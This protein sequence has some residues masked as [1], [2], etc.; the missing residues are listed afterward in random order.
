MEAEQV[1]QGG[2]VKHCLFCKKEID[3]CYNYCNWDCMVAE[4]KANGGQVICPNGLPIRSI[5]RDGNM[6]E[7][8]HGD[9]PDYKFP[10][11][12]L[13]VGPIDDDDR[14]RWTEFMGRPLTD[15]EVLRME[16]ETHAL[17]YTDGFIAVTMYE[18]CYAIF[19]LGTG[20]I[21]CGP[22]WL[23]KKEWTLSAYSLTQ[24]REYC[25]RNKIPT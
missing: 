6:Y 10:V 24:I 21:S 11:D 2:S 5:R 15:E 25:E 4:A 3:R 13:Y 8:E 1:A 22:S 19:N 14:K 7:H 23:R 9:H 20:M 17:I 12:V 16:D 18:C